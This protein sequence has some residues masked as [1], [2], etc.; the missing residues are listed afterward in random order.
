MTDEPNPG[1]D[2][3]LQQIELDSSVARLNENHLIVRL[4]PVGDRK[5][6]DF[7]PVQIS[8]FTIL[9]N[10]ELMLYR[11]SARDGKVVQHVVYVFSRDAWI[12]FERSVAPD[13]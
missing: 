6:P 3:L 10:G 12:S 8:D 1:V 5:V 4:P 13:A 9:P 7:L 2:E 11:A